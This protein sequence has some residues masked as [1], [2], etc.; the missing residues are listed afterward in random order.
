MSP[1]EQSFRQE[2]MRAIDDLSEGAS[3]LDELF[4]A[5]TRLT[6]SILRNAASSLDDEVT[7]RSV[8]DFEFALNDLKGVADELPAADRAA[9][10]RPLERLDGIVARLRAE[11]KLPEPLL[12]KI[13]V[14]RT[15]L[16]ERAA[17]IQRDTYRPPE[18][19]ATPLPHDPRSLRNEAGEI[20]HQLQK[21]GFDT[22]E[23]DRLVDHADDF[24]FS[25][26]NRLV[27]ELEVILS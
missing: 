2:L 15:K 9:F 22:P 24:Y 19:A 26:V 3:S 23:L 20:R 27:E 17:A 16:K 8:A 25:D 11:A 1:L 4:S 13:S 5:Q 14:L 10:D 6:I 12:E 18:V 7:P 21:A